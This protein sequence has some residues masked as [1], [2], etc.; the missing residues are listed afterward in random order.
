MKT[1]YL[2]LTLAAALLCTACSK[3]DASDAYGGY[4]DPFDGVR[5]YMTGIA[6]E[7]IAQ[8][9]QELE[10]ALAAARTRGSPAISTRRTARN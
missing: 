4:E 6:D 1:R 5:D 3:D 10:T 2:L 9:L 8:N 7:L